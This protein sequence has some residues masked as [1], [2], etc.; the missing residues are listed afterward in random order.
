MGRRRRKKARKI[1]RV[2]KTLPKVFQCPNCGIRA[3]T[4]TFPEK[5]VEP[6]SSR[7]ALIKCGHCKL[8]AKIEVPYVFHEVDAYSRFLDLFHEGKLEYTFME[9]EEEE[10]GEEEGLK[11]STKEEGKQ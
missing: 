2:R 5:R 11:L 9:E 8:Y 4:I 10:A 7:E 6:G 1:I 3:L